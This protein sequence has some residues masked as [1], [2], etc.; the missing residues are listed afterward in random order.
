MTKYSFKRAKFEYSGDIA[1]EIDARLMKVP[2][3]G[4]MLIELSYIE[5]YDDRTTAQKLHINYDELNKHR[6]LIVKYLSG[7][8]RKRTDYTQW[9]AINAQYYRRKSINSSLVSSPKSEAKS[10]LIGCT[11]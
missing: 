8:K 2:M 4:R 10:N 11:T 1:G 9:L 5:G 6:N 3:W 7:W